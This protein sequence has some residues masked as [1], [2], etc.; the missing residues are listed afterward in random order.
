MNQTRRVDWKFAK[1]H[2]RWMDQAD[3]LV[4]AQGMPPAVI[5]PFEIHILM[6]DKLRG[7]LDNFCKATLDYLDRID[8]IEGDSQKFLRKLTM[9][10]GDAP[11]GC[12]VTIRPAA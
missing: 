7:D 3:A 12:R 2:A 5:G 4:M 11:E 8:L 9:E 6:S 10:W 1:S